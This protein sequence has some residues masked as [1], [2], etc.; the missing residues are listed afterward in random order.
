MAMYVMIPVK[1]ETKKLVDL[2]KKSRGAAT[3]D[4][5]IAGAFK[6]KSGWEILGPIHGII[7]GGPPFVRDKSERTFD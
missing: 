2:A 6:Q 4:E 1:K 3:Y 5:V 7:K